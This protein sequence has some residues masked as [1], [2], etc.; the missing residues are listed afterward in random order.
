[1]TMTAEDTVPVD[2]R[3]R[4][5]GEWR[6]L[7]GLIV[8]VGITIGALYLLA[9]NADSSFSNSPEALIIP[10]ISNDQACTNFAR[11][12]IDES[13]LN[14]EPAVIEG[15]S[16][17]RLSGSGEW[18]VPKGSDDDRL[19]DDAHLTEIELELTES[20]RRDLL[21]QI[22]ALDA[23]LSS[24]I[25]NEID[26]IY[27]RRTQAITGHVADGEPISRPRSRYTRVV[28]A[29]LLDSQY[30]LL[31]D[32]VGWLMNQKIT[33]YD[34]LL[35]A[36]L[37]DPDIAYLKTACLGVEDSLSIRYPPWIWDLQSEVSLDAY[38]AHLARSGQLTAD[39]KS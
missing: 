22:S 9:R 27:S 1:M 2:T 38:L 21:M 14:L 5:G 18:F 29:F 6:V 16:N 36:C 12:W 10:K 30:T 25:Q 24:S 28:Q 3:I 19:P 37:N 11:Y 20:T 26:G 31:A 8:L 15:I 23:S 35:A 34:A 33:A 13:G 17:C 32:Y 4:S 7:L 39:T